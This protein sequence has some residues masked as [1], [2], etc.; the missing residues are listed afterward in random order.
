MK[1]IKNNLSI[2]LAIL[3]QNVFLDVKVFCKATFYK[4][5]LVVKMFMSG[6]KVFLKANTG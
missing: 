4:F 1:N 2:F 3:S 6:F 5:F